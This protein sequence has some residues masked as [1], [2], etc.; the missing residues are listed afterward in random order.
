MNKFID[1]P[2]SPAALLGCLFAFLA[3]SGALALLFGGIAAC[4]GGGR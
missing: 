2:D 4:A 3:L 1:T